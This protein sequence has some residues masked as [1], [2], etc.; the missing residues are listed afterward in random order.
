[1]T[2]PAL[3][4]FWLVVTVVSL[5]NYFVKYVFL[6]ERKRTMIQLKQLYLK[7]GS[8]IMQNMCDTSV[9]FNLNFMNT[10]F[11]ISFRFAVTPCVY[12]NYH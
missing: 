5:D 6:S 3:I 2:G 7:I 11:N 1:M 8:K 9:R 4:S 10:Y 12:L